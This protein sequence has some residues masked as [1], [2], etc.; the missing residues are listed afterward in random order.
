MMWT[1]LWYG[2]VISIFNSKP[3]HYRG[4]EGVIRRTSRRGFH[5]ARKTGVE[6]T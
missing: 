2:V 6:M 4:V 5:S 1:L 3:I